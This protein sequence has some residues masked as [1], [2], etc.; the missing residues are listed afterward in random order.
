MHEHRGGLSND[1]SKQNHHL[2]IEEV[3]HESKTNVFRT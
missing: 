1:S 3:A 2:V